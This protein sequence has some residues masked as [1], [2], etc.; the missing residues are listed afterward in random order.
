MFV[1]YGVLVFLFG[2][3]CVRVRLCFDVRVYRRDWLHVLL[4]EYLHACVW[5]FVSPFDV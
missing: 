4:C 1:E 3:E 2:F 5:V